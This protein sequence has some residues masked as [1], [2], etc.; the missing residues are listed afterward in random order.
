MALNNRQL[1]RLKPGRYG[2]GS[3]LY[4]EV[5]DSGARSWVF[6]YQRGPKENWIGLG[7]FPLI[8]LAKARAAVLEQK[9]LLLAGIDPLAARKAEQAKAALEASKMMTF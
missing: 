6:R 5:K 7:P 8:A 1:A 3:G 4:L 9:R 2:D